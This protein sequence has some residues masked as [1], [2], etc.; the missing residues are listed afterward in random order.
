M[1][2]HV[3]LLAVPVAAVSG[4]QVAN[5]AI[6]RD[7]TERKRAEEELRL[8]QTIVLAINEA[9]LTHKMKGGKTF[10]ERKAMQNK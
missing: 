3:S 6:Y 10:V 1:L 9:P 2:V 5:Y 7:I 4:E 8:L